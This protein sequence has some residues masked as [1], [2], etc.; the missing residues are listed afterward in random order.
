M[1]KKVA[2]FLLILLHLFILHQLQFTAWPEMLSFPY[3]LNH[4]FITY[5]D[6]VHAYPPLL[7][8]ILALIY[9][10]FGYKLL[11]Q[12]FFAWS[13]F[14]AN[15]ILIFFLIKKLTKR[16]DLSLIAVF[17]YVILQPILEGNMIWP[18]L[19]IVPFILLSF[20]LSLNKKY[21]LSGISIALALLTKQTALLYFMV[22]FIYLIFTERKLSKITVF[23]SGVAV[24]IIPFL[25]WLVYKNSFVEFLNWTIIYPSTFWTK[26]PGYVQFMPTL[27][28]TAILFA[29]AAPLIFLII[30]AKKK[31]F[32]DKYFYLISAFL[33]CGVIGVY[34]RFSFFHLQ[35]AIAFLVILYIYLCKY[36]TDK[37]FIVLFMIP[38]FSLFLSFKSLRFDEARFWTQTNLRLANVIQKETPKDKPVYLLGLDSD[39]YAFANRLPNSPWLDNFGWYLEIPGV[40]ENVIK[41]FTQNPPSSIFWVI[42][43]N[44]NWYDIGT[45][46]P[47]KITDWIQKNYN[48]D[49]EVEAGVWK[50]TK[51]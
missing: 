16:I 47:K 49:K 38:F 13:M 39:L 50:W 20:L 7:I 1:R 27:R 25:V 28:Q 51:K 34:P 31:F 40:Q 2:L 48:K 42:P 41:S 24:I 43:E 30:I 9:K 37:I 15:D 6:M 45:Y 29:L 5:K 12:E 44:G 35:P 21:F 19:A 11:V 17:A 23:L 18:D 46:Q 10:T 8:N 32:T 36:F 4:G 3:F 26:F 33:V 14:I 22:T